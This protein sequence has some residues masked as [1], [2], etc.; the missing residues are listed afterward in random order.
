MSDLSQKTCL[1]CEG[2]ATALTR[3]QAEAMLTALHAAWALSDNGA[4]IS[5]LFNF[6]DFYQTLSFVNAAA[7]VANS[8]DQE[9]NFWCLLDALQD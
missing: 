8:E 9:G 4:S 7:H 1:P 6:K 5:R 3:T 2:G